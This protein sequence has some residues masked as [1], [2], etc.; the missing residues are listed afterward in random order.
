MAGAGTPAGPAAGAGA[1]GRRGRALP[2]VLL[3]LALWAVGLGRDRLDAWVAATVLPPAVVATGVEVVDRDGRL[4]RAY[5]VADGRW[6]LPARADEVDRG[7][8]AML[9]AYEDRRFWRHAGVDPLALLRAGWQALRAGRPVSG[10][11]T[12]TMQV[13]RLLEESGTGRWSGKLRQ[14]RVA[15]ALE[16]RLDKA[17]ILGLYLDLAPMGGNLEGVRAAAL[18]W[19]GKEPR[20]LTPAEA[21]LLV[22]L[23]QAP[24]ARR[25]DRAPAAARAARDR[26]LVRLAGAGV[27]DASAA[28]A[29]Q[30]EPV[31]AARR[32]FPALAAHLADRLVAEAPLLRR[33]ATTIDAGLQARLERLAADTVAGEA[34]RL[35][36]AILV[37]DHATGAI[38]AEVGSAGYTDAARDGFVDMTRALRS[39]G[40]TLKPLVYGLAFDRGLAHPETLI[41]D[42]PVAFGTYAPQNFDRSFHGT[43]RVREA[44]QLSLN[45]PVVLVTEA[46][47]PETLLAALR[48]AG[49]AAEVPGGQP[50]LAVAL[51]GVGVSLEGLVTLYG[52]LARGGAVVPLHARAAAGGAP[53][54]LISPEAAWHLGDI[55]SGMP[56][57]PGAPASR[58]AYKTGTSYGHRDALALGFDGRHVAGVWL[59]R[60][61]GTAVPGAFG[62]GTAAPVLFETFA[63]LKAALDP[64]PPPPPATLI[65]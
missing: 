46:L 20:R 43:V 18:A 58:L 5:T 42:R 64:L 49:I 16:R 59:G 26:V 38:L 12:L 17:A 31:P 22:A 62:A 56:P 13:A 3:A 40:S 25:P 45:I 24:E 21:A 57:P 34:E 63:R 28:A 44:L 35:S 61:D 47:G 53:R 23:P 14:I 9:V 50:G 36:I 55:L 54:R 2:L 1:R 8:L 41:V 6:R 60:A 15:L 7:Y 52:G 65:A 30:G 27:L 37:A 48:R 11:S 19:F 51:G 33:H 32:P 29:A 39:P 10:G 4:L